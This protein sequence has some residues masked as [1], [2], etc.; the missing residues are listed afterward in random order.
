[1]DFSSDKWLVFLSKISKWATK[2]IFN[3]QTL[4]EIGIIVSA[5][6]VSKIVAWILN[7]IFKKG[8]S[9]IKERWP[10][11]EVPVNLITGHLSGIFFPMILF[12]V[13]SVAN[14]FD[15][16]TYFIKTV[17]VLFV[18]ILIIDLVSHVIS[19]KLL[20]KFISLIVSAVVAMRTF[21]IYDDVTKYLDSYAVDIGEIRVS[22]YF[23][24]KGLFV[25]GLLIWIAGL[26]SDGVSKKLTRST[27]LTPSLK[28]LIGKVF[29]IA[30]YLVATIFGLSALGVNLTAFAIFSGA[31]G[32]GIGFGLQKVFSNLISG[33]ILLFDNSIRPGDIIQLGEKFGTVKNM[34]GRYISVASWDG[35]E[36][37]IPNEDIV[38]GRVINWTH[39]NR[40]V[41][42][43]LE[44]GVSYNSDPHF[45]KELILKVID[46]TPR[47]LKDPAPSCNLK[48]FSDS[49][50]DFTLLCWIKDPEN[51]IGGLRSE[52]YFKIWDT[53]K[54]NNIEIPFPQRDIHI[55][56]NDTPDTT[57]PDN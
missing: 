28:V 18:I 49:S 11:L 34:G 33:F 45:A 47:V 12:T 51:G 43:S 2:N 55:I 50:I 25:F 29:G 35:T 32:V 52:I 17:A 7:K 48:G 46:S 26:A 41:M 1:M 23:I 9:K 40:N 27:H 30:A 5:L 13:N 16:R 6:A 19:N 21:N 8:I 15:Y 44:V 56:K 54:E 20:S 39:S 36:H 53:F 14:L 42:V 37:L 3:M 24:I 57:K 22:I 10:V 4:I 38:T 31:V